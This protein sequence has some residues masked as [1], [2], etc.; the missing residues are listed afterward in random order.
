MSRLP[1]ESLKPCWRS[2]LSLKPEANISAT[3]AVCQRPVCSHLDK[4]TSLDVIVE[5][6]LYGLLQLDMLVGG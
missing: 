3:C 6:C 1:N 4:L 5:L 2:C